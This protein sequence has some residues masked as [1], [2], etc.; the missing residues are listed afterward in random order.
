MKTPELT[1][2]QLLKILEI[3]A[4]KVLIELHQPSL[5]PM[6]H[7]HGDK[8][9]AVGCLWENEDQKLMALREIKLLCKKTN[10]TMIGFVSEAWI[11]KHSTGVDL[12]SV[13][14]PSQSPDRIEV[15]SVFVSD[16]IT[17]KTKDWQIMRNE[18][19]G[20]IL[21]LAPMNETTGKFKGRMIDGLLPKRTVH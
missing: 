16:G 4:H 9:I 14:L 21:C 10:A 6:Y 13:T 20:V 17:T 5:M 7:I 19:N 3:H 8:D 11:T 2:D 18:P 15:V 12:S 1:L